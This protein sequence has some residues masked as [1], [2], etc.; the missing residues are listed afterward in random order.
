MTE[1][2]LVGAA[3]TLI[4]A[5]ASGIG[6]LLR[7]RDNQKDPIPKESAAVALANQ[8]VAIM[9]GVATRLTTEVEQVKAQLAAVKAESE[10][11]KAMQD[12]QVHSLEAS[13][14]TLDESLSAAIRFIEQLMRH[15]MSGGREPKPA[16]PPQLHDLID[17]MLRRWGATGTAGV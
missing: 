1:T 16:I 2:G 10:R 4:L 3:V 5:A 14:E 8:S 12:A 17:P 11:T 9:M 15:T 7:R 6:Y 13:V